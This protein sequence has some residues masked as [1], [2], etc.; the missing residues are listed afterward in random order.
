MSIYRKL[1]EKANSGGKFKLD[2]NNKSLYLG[3]VQY[4]EKGSVLREGDLIDKDDL[5]DFNIELDLSSDCW[6]V[7]SYLF[8]KFKHS[9]PNSHWKD[10]SY[11]KALD[12]DDLTDE[13]LAFNCDRKLAQAMIE[14][15][16][17]CASL[18][19]WLKWDN[20]S[21]WFWQDGN[22]PECIVLK[23]WVK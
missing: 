15:Y 4:I 19:G 11:F 3:R 23:Q 7:V 21:H 6:S 2:L 9:V 8:D 20:E 17:L 16:I 10:K 12:V 18:Q 5:K 14:G 1:L 13:E 22:N